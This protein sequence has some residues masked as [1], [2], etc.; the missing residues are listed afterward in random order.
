MSVN[1]D[2]LPFYPKC[3]TSEK[4]EVLLKEFNYSK[5]PNTIAIRE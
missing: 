5:T 1:I 3:G 2:S 4:D